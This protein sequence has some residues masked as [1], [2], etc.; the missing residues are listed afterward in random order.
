M[1]AR[2]ITPNTYGV[3]AI[4]RTSKEEEK[5]TVQ[6]FTRQEAMNIVKEYKGEDAPEGYK[7]KVV[8]EMCEV[9]VKNESG[10]VIAM[11]DNFENDCQKYVDRCAAA[12]VKNNARAIG[13][14]KELI[15]L[16]GDNAKLDKV[17]EIVGLA[18]F[19]EYVD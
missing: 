17:L 11:V 5:F 15:D 6:A 2:T 7:I 10:E 18:D 9:E 4:N 14:V 13:K 1:E 12:K 3:W 19:K 8:A 16:L